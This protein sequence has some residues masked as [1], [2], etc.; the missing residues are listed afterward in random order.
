MNAKVKHWLTLLPESRKLR[1]YYFPRGT[2]LKAQ[3]FILLA[4]AA[5]GVTVPASASITY[6]CDPSLNT[7]SGSATT[8]GTLQTTIAG[9]YGSTF[10]NANANIYVTFAA[11]GSGS[12]LG[13]S[14]QRLGLATYA[15]YLTQLT[16][17]EGDAN[18]A[19]AVASLATPGNLGAAG[20]DI[21][22][23]TAL[24]NAL[25]FSD[26][27]GTTQTGGVCTITVS[28]TTTCFNG[29]I[30]LNDPTDLASQTGGQGYYYRTGTQTASEYDFYSVIEHE[31]DEILGTISC[32]DDSA[33]TAVDGC[34]ATSGHNNAAPTDL[35]RYASP[36]TRT[37]LSADGSPA[38]FS[39]DSGTTNIANYNNTANG[40]DYGDWALSAS[41]RIQD[42]SACLGGSL[43]IT[44]DGGAEVSVL[45]AVGYNL[46][47]SVPEPTTFGLIGLGLAIAGFASRRRQN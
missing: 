9:L 42:Y 31:T 34:G 16:N 3:R 24:A 2:R 47:A 30:T 36:G 17:N 21:L 45:D 43:D 6:M 8:C 41:C 27:I 1:T 14:Q 26:A 35:F 20:G 33:G 23:T 32:I 22:L 46:N 28:N 15:Q 40:G 19:T 11:T 39:I 37:F 25:G 18:D 13:G 4:L 7:D 38:Y 10:S 5:L 29:V 12:G 44:N